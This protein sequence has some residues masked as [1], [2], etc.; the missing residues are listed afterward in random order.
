MN[1]VSFS[2]AR[3]CSAGPNDDC[4]LDG[5]WTFD[6]FTDNTD[7]PPTGSQNYMQFE[8]DGDFIDGYVRTR[9][10]RARIDPWR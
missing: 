1:H 2:N 7:P 3:P 6:V 5:A 8:S 9:C 4:A 10:D